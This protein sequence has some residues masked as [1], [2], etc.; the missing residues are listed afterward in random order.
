MISRILII[1]I[2]SLLANFSFAGEMEYSL[3]FS[4][5]NAQTNKFQIKDERRGEGEAFVYCWSDEASYK[6]HLEVT[7]GGKNF[8]FSLGEIL[9]A[10]SMSCGHLRKAVTANLDLDEIHFIYD[11]ATLS[12]KRINSMP[13]GTVK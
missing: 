11:G 1:C 6:N 12:V 13:K 2:L 8:Y 3:T 5:Y 9:A 7:I 10:R 4:S